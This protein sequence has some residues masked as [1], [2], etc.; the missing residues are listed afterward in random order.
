MIEFSDSL[1]QQEPKI[2]AL[3]NIIFRI[4]GVGAGSAAV[5]LP[6]VLHNARCAV[7]LFVF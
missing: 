6:E 5:S 3:T 4:L 7:N 2:Q 1:Q